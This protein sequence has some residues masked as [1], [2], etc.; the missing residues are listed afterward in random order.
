VL[1]AHSL[2]MAGGFMKGWIW[3]IIQLV[4]MLSIGGLISVFYL[5]PQIEKEQ[6]K[7]YMVNTQ[8]S[9]IAVVGFILLLLSFVVIGF[10]LGG[11]Y[12]RS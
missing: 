8:N 12:E 3:Q 1:A 2:K 11:R 6:Q 4:V 10:L 5:N 7:V 9:W